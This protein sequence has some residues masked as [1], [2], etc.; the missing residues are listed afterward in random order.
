MPSTPATWNDETRSA[1]FVMSTEQAD[2]DKDIIRQAGLDLTEFLKNPVALFMHRSY[3]FPIGSW[4]NVSK[5]MEQ[6]PRTEGDL[7]FTAEEVDPEA[8]RAA[9]HVRAGTLRA[10]S[11]GFRPKTLRA[12]ERDA[13]E[14]WSGYEIIEAELYECSLVTVPA[15]PAAL[16]K[17]VRGDEELRFARDTIEEVLDRYGRDPATRAVVSRQ[18][19]EKAYQILPK[20]A[21]KGST[22]GDDEAWKACDTCTNPGVCGA[23]GACYTGGKS[24]AP[25]PKAAPMSAADRARAKA[26]ALR[27][28][29]S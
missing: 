8:D 11:I 10:V 3:H 18:D 20:R 13:D 1:R 19:F 25:S 4:H 15:N 6:V 27:L 17:S 28:R 24:A 5:A 29:A 26:A 16:A 9:R 7:V 12:R 22:K 23:A 14:W 2:R 21:P